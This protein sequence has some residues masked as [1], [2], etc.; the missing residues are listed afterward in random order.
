V[1]EPI[2]ADEA[3]LWC[4]WPDSI[5]ESRLLRE[6][7]RLLSN[8]ERVTLAR[9]VFPEDRHLYLVSRALVRTALSKYINIP[10]EQLIFILNPC[11]RP[12]LSLPASCPPITFNLTHTRGLA[13]CLIAVDMQVGVDVENAARP[14]FCMNLAANSLSPLEF[15]DLQSLPDRDRSHRFFEYWTLKESYIKARG[16]GLSLPLQKVSFHR[17]RGTVRVSFDSSLA[18]HSANW[19][20]ALY[21]PRPGYILATGVRRPPGTQV[22]IHQRN[23]VPLS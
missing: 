10:A 14:I 15:A 3:H 9:F 1:Y 20:F 23:T 13:A 22:R 7:H 18:D 8:E 11:G 17:E 2:G 12:E 21:S 19:Q 16:M 4:V 6:Y 5:S